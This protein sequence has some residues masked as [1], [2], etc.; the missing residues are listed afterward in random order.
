[1]KCQYG[2]LSDQ[3]YQIFLLFDISQVPTKIH[4]KLLLFVKTKIR[5]QCIISRN[6]VSVTFK[7]VNEESKELI[8]LLATLHYI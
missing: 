6:Q 1:M 5:I 3:E 8:S 2:Q 4:I 7:T